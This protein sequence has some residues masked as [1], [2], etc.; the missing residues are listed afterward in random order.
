MTERGRQV[1]P[2]AESLDEGLAILKNVG[3]ILWTP[4]ERATK[5]PRP[6]ERLPGGSDPVEKISKPLAAGLADVAC[7][8][9]EVT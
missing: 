9:E 8:E 6:C 2:E 3:A 1:V 5:C 7:G 4:W